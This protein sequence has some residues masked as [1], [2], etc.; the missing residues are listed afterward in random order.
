MEHAVHDDRDGVEKPVAP[1]LMT[2]LDKAIHRM[3]RGFTFWRFRP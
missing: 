2:V 3:T 1:L